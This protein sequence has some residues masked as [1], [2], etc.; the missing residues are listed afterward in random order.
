MYV[1]HPV[2][3]AMK[4]TKPY[5]RAFQASDSATSNQHLMPAPSVDIPLPISWQKWAMKGLALDIGEQFSIAIPATEPMPLPIRMLAYAATAVVATAGYIWIR[6]SLFAQN[7]ITMV[8][9]KETVM[10]CLQGSMQYD[11]WRIWDWLTGNG[12]FVCTDW[13]VQTRFGNIPRFKRKPFSI[14]SSSRTLRG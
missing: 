3:G 6:D 1:S 11:G 5:G 9:T 13:K 8:T 2:S 4:Q 14:C 12:Y 10:V 7:L